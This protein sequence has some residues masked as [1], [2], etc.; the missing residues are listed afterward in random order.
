MK[1]SPK[2]FSAVEN[3]RQVLDMYDEVLYL[4]GYVAE[5]E[6]YRQKYIDLLNSSTAHN[7]HMIGGLLQIAMKPGVLNALKGG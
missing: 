4:R 2:E 6:E 3:A 5:L 1:S 7:E